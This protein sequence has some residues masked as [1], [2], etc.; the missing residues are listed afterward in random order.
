MTGTRCE[1][2]TEGAEDIRENLNAS[3]AGVSPATS[4]REFEV[5]LAEE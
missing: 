1:V 5:L 4:A 2:S 3:T